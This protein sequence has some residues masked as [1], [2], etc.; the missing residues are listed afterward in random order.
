MEVGSLADRFAKLESSVEAISE[1]LKSDNAGRRLVVEP[2]REEGNQSPPLPLGETDVAVGTFRD[3][4]T[5]FKNIRDSLV[6]V[7]LP[8]DLVVGDSRAGVNK[9]DWPK[10]QVIQK[11]ARFQ[12]TTLKL[13]SQCASTEPVLSEFTTI[14][15]AQLRYL[16]EEYTNLLVANQFDEGT[17][18]LFQTLQQNP[19]S[20]TPGALENLQRAVSIAGARQSRQVS[21]PGRFR[22]RGSFFPF[23][24]GGRGYH[25]DPLGQRPGPAGPG[26]GSAD[27]RFRRGRFGAAAG[28]RDTS[29]RVQPEEG[30]G[31]FT[32]A[33]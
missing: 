2:A 5:E 1:Q 20:F 14:A 23:S 26:S 28:S 21:G 30:A 13:L 12:E 19:A 31:A 8:P 17:T 29:V 11:C 24:A 15:L 33:E 22:G 6:K 3:L 25:P 10:F 16:Q 4:Q 32:G 27:W 18:K 9:S 7:K